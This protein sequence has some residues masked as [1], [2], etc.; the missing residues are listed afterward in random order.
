M[1]SIPI[2]FSVGCSVYNSTLNKSEEELIIEA[3][4]NMYL[5]KAE[6]KNLRRRKSDK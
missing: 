4:N 6:N 5:N 2:N 3:D 1:L